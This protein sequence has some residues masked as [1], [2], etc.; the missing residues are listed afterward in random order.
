ML[1][2]ASNSEIPNCSKNRAWIPSMGVNTVVAALP[3][4][5]VL[6]ST[7]GSACVLHMPTKSAW[8]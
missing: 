4:P 1:M 6:Y 7:K 3:I 8:V 2:A 5:G